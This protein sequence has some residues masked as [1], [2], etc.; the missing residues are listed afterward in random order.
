MAEALA[1]WATYGAVA[2]E[3]AVL[4]RRLPDELRARRGIGWRAGLGQALVF[5]GHPVTLAAPALGALALARLHHRQIMPALARATAVTATATGLG[6]V[7][8]KRWNVDARPGDALAA[9]GTGLA[10]ALTAEAVRTCGVGE[11]ATWGGDDRF[12]LGAAAVIVAVGLPWIFADAGVYVGD[13]PIIGGPYAS[14]GYVHLGHHHGT[15]GLLLALTA[16]ALSRQ[17]GRV[18]SGPQREALS[19]YLSLLLVYGIARAA[20]DAWHE[21]VWKRGWTTF[22]LPEVVKRGRPVATPAW[23]VL[24]G[25]AGL[26]HG[27]WSRRAD[28]VHR[29]RGSD[30]R[31]PFRR[32]SR[33]G[34]IGPVKALY[35][36]GS[37]P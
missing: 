14:R 31:W 35:P 15:D 28:R 33:T 4:Y 25:A 26:V 30:A 12:R 16:L 5:L 27:R 1:V 24:L 3:I 22:V 18:R 19:G 23:G 37:E 20:Q 6:A 13:M 11:A 8:V 21:Q 32:P 34:T 36:G 17:I 7:A 9:A 10:L 29:V 2:T